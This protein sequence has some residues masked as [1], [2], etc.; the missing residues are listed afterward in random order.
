MSDQGK[1]DSV[2]LV[3]PVEAFAERI[4]FAAGLEE[5]QRRVAAGDGAKVGTS[6][7][8]DITVRAA[9][10]ALTRYLRAVSSWPFRDESQASRF[11]VDPASSAE[12][13]DVDAIATA[14]DRRMNDWCLIVSDGER[15]GSKI[16]GVQGRAPIEAANDINGGSA[17]EHRSFDDVYIALGHK[18]TPPGPG[19][20]LYRGH[21][22]VKP[23]AEGYEPVFEGEF[24]PAK[25]YD[26]RVMDIGVYDWMFVYD[27]FSYDEHDVEQMRSIVLAMHAPSCSQHREAAEFS[28]PDR[29]ATNEEHAT[30]LDESRLYLEQGE[31]CGCNQ[32]AD[33]DAFDKMLEAFNGE[34]S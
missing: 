13:E 2:P 8:V 1:D 27:E 21:F 10:V 34:P 25:P 17:V 11:T 24:R 9:Q 14:L 18:I 4:D 30:A 31:P 6:V 26:L 16:V 20:W 29:L 32:Y 33:H 7:V 5:A 23:S 15:S 22:Y 19:L 28:L 12:Q 3:R